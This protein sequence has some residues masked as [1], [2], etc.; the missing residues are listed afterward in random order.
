MGSDV[1]FPALACIGVSEFRPT[2]SYSFEC[3]TL[4]FDVLTRMEAMLL[5]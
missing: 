3:V 5:F 4:V 2:I 1:V